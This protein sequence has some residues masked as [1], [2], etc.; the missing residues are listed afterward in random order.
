MSWNGVGQ[1]AIGA[2]FYLSALSLS[3]CSGDLTSCESDVDCIILCE[4]P[5]RDGTVTVGPFSCRAGNCGARH[6][7]ERDCERVCS[8]PPGYVPPPD[9]DDDSS[10]GD[11]DDSG[12]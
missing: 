1:A 9:D 11:D 10:V 7:R 12:G 6:L 5:D 2:A 3:G 4:C 8:Q